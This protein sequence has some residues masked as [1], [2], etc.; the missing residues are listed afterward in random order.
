MW[1]G[2]LGKT[3]GQP[4][5]KKG[6][7]I[8]VIVAACVLGGIVASI[9]LFVTY[10]SPWL[11][12][13][14]VPNPIMQSGVGQTLSALNLESMH[15]SAEAVALSDLAD[16]VVLLTIWGTW[17]PPCREELPHLA[18]LQT[19]FAGYR[20]FRMLTVSYPPMDQADDIES[21]REETRALLVKLKLD[22]PVYD[23]P[24]AVT[25]G[26]LDRVIHLRGYPTTILLDRRGVI[27]AVWAGY[28]AGVETEMERIVDAVLNERN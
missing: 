9:F 22:L 8:A 21:L 26:E 2:K 15:G 3:T 19:R 7:L 25:R 5:A 24:G 10:I 13:R 18:K 14:I 16:K 23:D 27:R 28:R 1:P 11:P 12:Q 17:C 20:T 4:S 6:Y